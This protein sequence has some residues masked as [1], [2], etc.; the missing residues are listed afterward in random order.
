[1]RENKTNWFPEGPDIQCFVILILLQRTSTA[2]QEYVPGNVQ[3][4]KTKLLYLL[5]MTL[6][7]NALSEKILPSTKLKFSNDNECKATIFF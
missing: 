5:I 4:L 3:R 7:F 1:M 2:T 6:I